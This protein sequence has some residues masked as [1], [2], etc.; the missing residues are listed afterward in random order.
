MSPKSEELF[1]SSL[2]FTFDFE[3]KERS[4][5]LF[6]SLRIVNVYT[7]LSV[8]DTSI[9]FF[10]NKMDRRMLLERSCASNVVNLLYKSF[11]FAIHSI[12]NSIFNSN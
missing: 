12:F 11:I 1:L 2:S 6:S 8:K 3:K 4:F 7:D 9:G 5:A 10:R